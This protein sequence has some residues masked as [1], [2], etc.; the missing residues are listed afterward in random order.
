MTLVA[1]PVRQESLS[2]CEQGGWSVRV[3][4]YHHQPGWLL[5]GNKSRPLLAEWHA[6]R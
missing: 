1:A 5:F 3:Q 6:A 4:L 2:S